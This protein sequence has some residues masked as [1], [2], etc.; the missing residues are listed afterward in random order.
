MFLKLSVVVYGRFS[1]YKQ[2]TKKTSKPPSPVKPGT[3]ILLELLCLTAKTNEI[4]LQLLN[5]V[6]L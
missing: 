5:T 6:T 2:Y 1:V 3:V 4:H